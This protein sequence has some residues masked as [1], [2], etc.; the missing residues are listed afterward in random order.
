MLTGLRS[1]PILSSRRRAHQTPNFKSMPFTPTTS[2]TVTEIDKRI[3]RLDEKDIICL[4]ANKGL[5]SARDAH[6]AK[7][8]VRSTDT[9]EVYSDSPIEV[10]I[11]IETV[12]EY[13]SLG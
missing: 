7:I 8:T 13:P 4:M 11:C 9:G 1:D 6:E 3:F 10:T 12:G 5:I 2:K